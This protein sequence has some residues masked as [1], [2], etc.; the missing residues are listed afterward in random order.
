MKIL[1]RFRDKRWIHWM[2]G[3]TMTERPA[4]RRDNC[5]TY[6]VVRGFIV[7]IWVTEC[8]CGVVW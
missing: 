1:R 5:L 3:H 7:P 4:E 2:L 8:S 6:A